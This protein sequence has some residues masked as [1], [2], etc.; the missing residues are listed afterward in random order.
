MTYIQIINAVL[1]RLREDEVASP[2]DTEYSTLIGDFVNETKREVEAAWNW[3]ALRTT[4]TLSAD[5][6]T[7]E[8]TDDTPQ[9]QV[10][11]RFIDP[12]KRIYMIDS[13]GNRLGWLKAKHQT[14]PGSEVGSS[15]QGS[16]RSRSQRRTR[17]PELPQAIQRP[18]GLI[19]VWGLTRSSPAF[20]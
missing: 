16:S 14:A 6:A 20:S 7:T 4:I 15:I 10:G 3:T 11:W 12:K 2:S 1:R 19:A 9:L 5:N 8:M 17:C 13:G 18:S